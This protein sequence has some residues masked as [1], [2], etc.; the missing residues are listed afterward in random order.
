MEVPGCRKEYI[1]G[2]GASG[3]RVEGRGCGA[4]TG[5]SNSGG[6]SGRPV[7]QVAVVPVSQLAS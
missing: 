6:G 1:H 4:I 3:G 5:N 7:C 2:V